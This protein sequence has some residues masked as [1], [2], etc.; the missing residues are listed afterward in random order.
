ME[1]DVINGLYL[2]EN[3]LP[4]AIPAKK[5][6]CDSAQY[7]VIDAPFG[8]LG[9]L[10]ELVD[11]SLMLSKIEYLAATAPLISPQNQLAK[12]V[13]EQCKAYF[14]DPHYQFHLPLKPAGTLHQ[15]KV[16]D[17]I[18]LIPVGST[19]NYGELAKKI[20]SGPRAVGTACGANPYPLISPCHRVVAKQ[21]IG[22]FMRENSPGLHRQIKIWL[23]KHE[24]AV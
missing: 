1:I 6:F 17:Q 16:W 7:C 23:L 8:R 4:M 12:E 19:T 20:K 13:A 15:Q 5:S 11:D 2:C 22:G 21:G 14:K 3:D 9:I 18:R 10:T 24:G